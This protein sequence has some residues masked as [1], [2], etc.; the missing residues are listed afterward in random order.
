MWDARKLFKC[1]ENVCAKSVF[2]TNAILAGT[3]EQP[4]FACVMARGACIEAVGKLDERFPIFFNDVDYCW[5]WREKGWQWHYLPSWRVQHHQGA[6]VRRL[7][8]CLPEVLSSV[9]RF[10][11]LRYG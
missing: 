5:R 4:A 1:V 7:D 9:I 3:V 10:A 6:S 2:L 8:Y 11:R